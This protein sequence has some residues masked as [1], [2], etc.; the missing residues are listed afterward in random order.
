MILSGE[1]ILERLRDGQIFRQGTWDAASIMEASYALRLA[2]DGLLVSGEFYDPGVPYTGS[3]ISIEPGEIAI[4]STIERLNM[5]AD[6]LGKIGLRLDAALKGLVGLMG[7]QVDPLYGQDQDD[8]R[9]Y[10]RVAN[11]GNETVKFLPREH[12][13][14]FELHEVVG[15]VQPP[16]PPKLPTWP[17]L[18]QQL[19]SQDDS[20]WSYVTRVRSETVQAEVR[21]RSE[22]TNIRDYLQPLVMFG[23]FLV[24]VTILGVAIAVIVSVRDTPEAAVPSWV[25]GWGWILLMGTLTIATATTAA[26]GGL[27]VWWLAK[28]R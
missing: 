21:V 1:A 6:L 11:F 13:F 14:T 24:A 26:I 23:I 7:I 27:T 22:L 3:Y 17:R 2:N 18:K 9:L 10:I 4:L 28:G 15:G 20:S 19:A 12:V 16:S 25:T 8:E 5:P